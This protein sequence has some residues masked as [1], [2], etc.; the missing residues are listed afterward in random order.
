MILG[1]LI[2][3]LLL[4]AAG[5]ALGSDLVTWYETSAFKLSTASALWVRLN[6]DSLS[7][8]QATIQHNAPAWVWDPG[9]AWILR[10]PGVA[11]LVV[12]GLLLVWLFRSSDER[13]RRA[14]MRADG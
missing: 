10:S 4:L 6:P 3:W 13:R 2:G 12:P 14:Q 1:R 8:A 9:I 11:V 5:V 7:V